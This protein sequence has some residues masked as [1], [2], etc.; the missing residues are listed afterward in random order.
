MPRRCDEEEVDASVPG[1]FS[2]LGRRGN[3]PWLSPQYPGLME[4][5]TERLRWLRPHERQTQCLYSGTFE[6]QDAP[7]KK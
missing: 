1:T 2:S 6:S 5:L 7:K 3:Q 4:G